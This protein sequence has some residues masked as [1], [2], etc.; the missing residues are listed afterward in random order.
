MGH[1]MVITHILQKWKVHY[2]VHAV[3]SFHLIGLYGISCIH[4]S[5]VGNPLTL[6]QLT[7]CSSVFLRKLI[8]GHLVQKETALMVTACSA[9]SAPS[10]QRPKQE[11]VYCKKSAAFCTWYHALRNKRHYVSWGKTI[12]CSGRRGDLS[13]WVKRRGCETD[14]SHSSNA[15]TTYPRSSVATSRYVLMACRFIK[16]RENLDVMTSQEAP[17]C[18]DVSTG[19]W[20][21][22]KPCNSV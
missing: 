7:T 1:N 16:R 12:L 21:Y 13:L 18:S 9:R 2:A 6:Y 4:K 15:E 19:R 8:L 5:D 3:S 14:N 11:Q 17:W 20:P 10:S 22:A